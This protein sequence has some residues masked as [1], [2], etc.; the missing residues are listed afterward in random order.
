[1]LDSHWRFECSVCHQLYQVS[2]ALLPLPAH[3]QP[4]NGGLPCAGSQRPGFP[5]GA[6]R[7]TTGRALLVSA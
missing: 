6:V 7:R 4:Q 1:M 2:E 3:T 5:R